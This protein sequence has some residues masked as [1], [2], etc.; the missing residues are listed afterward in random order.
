MS[1]TFRP[2][3]ALLA[4][5]AILALANPSPAQ[6][7]FGDPV[8]DRMQKDIFFLASPDCEG[9]GIE[10]KGIELAAGYVAETFQKAGLKPAMKDGTYF[11]PF[12]V[13]MSAKLG[14]PN[15]FT[16]TGPNGAK[17][18]PKLGTDYNPMG[19]SP[20]SRAAG[21]LVFAGF[22]ISAPELKYDDYAGLDVRGKIVVIFRRAPRY[23]VKDDKRFDT[24]VPAGAESRRADY[25]QRQH[26]GRQDRCAPEVLGPR[27]RYDAGRVPRA[28]HDARHPRRDPRG[29]EVE[30]RQ[31][32]RSG[33]RRQTEAAV[34]RADGLEG[35][36]AGDRGPQGRGVQERRRRAGRGRAAEGR[37][38]GDRRAL[39]PR[40]VRAVGQ[41]RRQGRG[42]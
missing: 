17:V 38:R 35:R 16:L 3:A 33:D 26:R 7:P 19:F 10:T 39:R 1:G 2:L 15:A 5:G 27:R 18:E 36:R 40:R 41:R 11:Q 31:R 37:N 25:R 28:V 32:N 13:T 42:G 20:T 22:G 23:D 34:V 24:T 4:F 12:R 21:D 29:R 9:R 8:L 14:T 6:K 30:V